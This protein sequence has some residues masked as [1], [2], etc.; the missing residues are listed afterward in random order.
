MDE[1]TSAVDEDTER[2]LYQLLK[3]RLGNVAVLSIAHRATVSAFHHRQLHIE[4]D[5][6]AITASPLR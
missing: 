3:E 4:P 6:Q 5:R 2:H 1:A